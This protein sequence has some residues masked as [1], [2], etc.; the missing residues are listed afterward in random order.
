MN[1]TGREE[2][3]GVYRLHA[4]LADRVSQRREGANRLYVSLLLGLL[5]FLG[6]LLRFG[7]DDVLTRV[8]FGAAGAFG[9]L[10]SASWCVVIR[11]YRQLNA[12]KFKTLRHLE[13]RLAYRFFSREWK[14][15]GE[16]E[17]VSLYWRL[18]AAESLVPALFAAVFLVLFAFA[19]VS[20]MSWSQEIGMTFDESI[21]R[22]TL[23]SFVARAPADELRPLNVLTGPKPRRK[24]E[25]D[26]RVRVAQGASAELRRRRRSRRP[27]GPPGVEGLREGGPGRDW[28]HGRQVPLDVRPSPE[29]A[30]LPASAR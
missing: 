11:S 27:G 30:S 28:G 7:G 15:L 20:P 14:V 23:V 1:D 5:L 26:W 9:A 2:L 8:L 21:R 19:F 12:G 29:C 10:L 13:K 3:L 6:A 25:A 16:G 4:E 24:D 22:E 17:N 18:S